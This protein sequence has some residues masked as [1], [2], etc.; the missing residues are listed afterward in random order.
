M[1]GNV[2]GRKTIAR[3]VTP[4][5]APRLFQR[6]D[7]CRQ[8]PGALSP[9]S[10]FQ[11]GAG[12]SGQFAWGGG[13]GV[14]PPPGQDRLFCKEPRITALEQELALPAC[15]S[16]SDLSAR[17]KRAGLAPQKTSSGLRGG[18][19]GPSA[20]LPS[21]LLPSS[22]LGR[23]SGVACQSSRRGTPARSPPGC[24]PGCGA[25]SA[26]VPPHPPRKGLEVLKGPLTVALDFYP[27]VKT[28]GDCFKVNIKQH[29]HNI[30]D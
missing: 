1:L 22:S 21:V 13:K 17:A 19:A 15:P 26:I 4:E 25:V 20:G 10:R 9:S 5:G 28:S 23:E 27:L 7:L 30:R 3:T 11:S 29:L 8:S 14:V 12:R 16:S 24:P 6:Q 18:G 2:A